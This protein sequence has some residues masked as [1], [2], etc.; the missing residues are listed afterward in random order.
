M[1]HSILGQQVLWER[2]CKASL[3]HFKWQANP[4]SGKGSRDHTSEGRSQRKS[5]CHQLQPV[6]HS[7][8]TRHWAFWLFPLVLNKKIISSQE[9]I[10][11]QEIEIRKIK[12]GEGVPFKKYTKA[13]ISIYTQFQ[14]LWSLS[15]PIFPMWHVYYSMFCG[16]NEPQSMLSKFPLPSCKFFLS[17][18][19][20]PLANSQTLSTLY[21]L[22]GNTMDLDSGLGVWAVGSDCHG[23]QTGFVA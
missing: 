13:S 6:L 21:S 3:Q 18:H 19:P 20:K 14:I 15:K 23:L 2:F 10:T 7:G 1:H 17:L 22:R 4:A 8:L 16:S 9:L 11:E 12:R 5:S